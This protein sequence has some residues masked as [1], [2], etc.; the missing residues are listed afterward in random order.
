M[1]LP[2]RGIAYD[3]IERYDMHYDYLELSRGCDSE[4]GACV[5]PMVAGK[6]VRIKS[7]DAVSEMGKSMLIV[8]GALLFNCSSVAVLID[9]N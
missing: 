1:P 2:D 8:A 5:V 4:C 3:R 9:S 7:I 6:G